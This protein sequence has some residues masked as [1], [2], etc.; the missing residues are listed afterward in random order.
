MPMRAG[1]RFGLLKQE[2]D[3]L[4]NLCHLGTVEVGLSVRRRKPG[5]SEQHVPLSKWNVERV[6]EDQHHLLRRPGVAG[7]DAR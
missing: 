2:R 7:F 1:F 4:W 5:H 6:R 3:G